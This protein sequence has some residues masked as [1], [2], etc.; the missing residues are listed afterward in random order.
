MTAEAAAE[1]VRRLADLAER[2]AMDATQEQLNGIAEELGARPARII[3][4]GRF[5]NGKSTLL[6]ALLA[7]ATHPVGASGPMVVDTLPA[8]AV[9]T[10]V[11]YAETPYVREWS[12]A[13]EVV[14]R[15]F[16]H[17][18]EAA[19]LAIDEADSRLKFGGVREFEVGYPARIAQRG[20]VLYDSPGL[21]ESTA[22]TLITHEYARQCDAVV[23]VYRND[24]PM[25]AVEMAVADE[26]AE[27]GVRVFTVINLFA[28]HLDDRFEEFAWNRLVRDRGGAGAQWCGQNL[29]AHGVYLVDALAAERAQRAGQQDDG[30]AR[31]AERLYEF[32]AEHRERERVRPLIEQADA[33]AAGIAEHAER[34]GQ[35]LREERVEL[36]Q[37][38]GAVRPRLEAL[39]D[40]P[41]RI[42]RA[43]DEHRPQVEATLVHS[44]HSLINDVGAG[45]PDHLAGAELPSARLMTSSLQVKRL[46]REANEIADR[47]LN[48]RIGHWGRTDAQRLL[49]EQLI[50][51][52]R[53]VAAEVGDLGNEIDGLYRELLALAP[54]SGPVRAS[55]LLTASLG[56]AAP[57]SPI[58]V[59]R[60]VRGATLHTTSDS[61]AL[62]AMFSIIGAAAVA[63]APVSFLG[64]AVMI[65]PANAE[66]RAKALAAQEADAR[67][68]KL[69]QVAEPALRLQVR[70]ALDARQN[71]LARLL[72]GMVVEEIRGID[73]M[74]ML[75]ARA[76]DARW[77]DLTDLGAVADDVGRERERL[78]ALLAAGVAP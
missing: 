10:G 24:A 8:T 48:E 35:A 20:A 32:I 72:D 33:L 56:S 45:L 53:R 16:E 60:P 61:L 78:A 15:D 3:F 69:A 58:E 62:Q 38:Y 77:R 66:A 43:F 22:R 54:A 25:G 71:E 6:N 47:Y 40:R 30:L 59:A 39:R 41:L 27:A 19:A 65:G 76:E 26:L 55:R 34:R 23:M 21:D 64:A 1:S 11:R 36:T 49:Q 12:L 14:D 46:L 67:L 44:F 51:L 68:A 7:D 18:A 9:I 5:K 2:A 37:R 74:V 42:N 4:V 17:F 50:E 70:D 75:V 57:P 29:A 73:G 13:G 28:G 52:E 63:I 31:L